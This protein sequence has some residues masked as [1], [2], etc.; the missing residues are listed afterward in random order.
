MFIMAPDHFKDMT[1]VYIGMSGAG[2]LLLHA[3]GELDVNFKT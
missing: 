3:T 1:Y 2:F